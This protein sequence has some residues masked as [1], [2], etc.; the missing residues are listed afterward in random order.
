MNGTLQESS[1]KAKSKCCEPPPSG[2]LRLDVDAGFN[3]ILGLCSA[4]AVIRNHRGIICAAAAECYRLSGTV[5]DAEIRA[6]NFGMTLAL[7]SGFHRV[8]VFSDS[9]SAVQEV[10]FKKVGRDPH[11]VLVSNI[12]ENLKSGKFYG[13]NHMFRSAN[14]SAHCLAIFGLSHPSPVRW[15]GSLYPSWLM[16]VTSLDAIN[17]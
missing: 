8:W 5:L 13:V 12:L 2:H 15:V 1:L 14:N 3:E 4:A 16:D 11:G 10:H 9:L 6:I 7:Q 17:V